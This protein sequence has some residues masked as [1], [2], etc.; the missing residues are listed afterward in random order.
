MFWAFSG[1]PWAMVEAYGVV[2]KL[3]PGVKALCPPNHV[4]DIPG[5]L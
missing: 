5:G 2:V 4:S 3:A 1:G